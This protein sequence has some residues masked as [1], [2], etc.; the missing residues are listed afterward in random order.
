VLSSNGPFNG[1]AFAVGVSFNGL[2]YLIGG[3]GGPQVV[4]CSVLQCVVAVCV[5][6]L[7]MTGHLLWGCRPNSCFIGLLAAGARR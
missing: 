6:A 3:C 5:A 1:R 2:L 7:L 4:C